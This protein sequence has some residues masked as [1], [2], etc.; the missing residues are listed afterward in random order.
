MKAPSWLMPKKPARLLILFGVLLGILAAEKIYRFWQPT[1]IH[2]TK[3]YHIQSS[4]EP[5][6]TQE[7]GRCMEVLHSTYQSV[8][9][10]LSTRPETI[11]RFQLKLYRDQREF[12]RCNRVRWA[13]AYY[14]HP[15]CHAY[16]SAEEI[17]PHHWMLHEG[18]HQLN[19]E[20][21]QLELSQW[22]D[23]G[24]ATYFSTSVLQ[25]DQLQIGTV[26][27]NTYPVWWL[28]E[29]KLS[30]NLEHDLTN[31]TIIPLHAII[32]G[33]GGPSINKQFNLYYLHWWSLVHMTF[34]A[35]N[36]TYRPGMLKVLQE[37]G[38]LAALEKHLMPLEQLQTEWYQHLC[39]LQWELFRIKSTP[40]NHSSPRSINSS[41]SNPR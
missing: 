19:R 29:L 38:S 15:F 23:E 12:K 17:N 21:S 14:R 30:G 25:G 31:E 9:H 5:S 8:F 40:T 39:K 27:R 37:G 26:D 11:N 24:L 34:E 2:D 18:I 16:Y 32:T 6:Q 36:G 35:N 28:D 3:H 4:A 41:S 20:L 10:E 22:A 1:H 33:R 7:V 13:E